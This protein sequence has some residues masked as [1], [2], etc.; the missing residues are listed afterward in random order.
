MIANNAR[1]D[2][3]LYGTPLSGQVH[4]A[5]WLLRMLELPYRP[6]DDAAE[7]RSSL[8]FRALNP[9]RQV[10]VLIDGAA[11]LADS[12]AILVYLAAGYAHG[13]A[14]LSRQALVAAQVQRWLSDAAGE[15]RY[16]PASARRV[17][18][19]KFPADLACALQIAGELLELMEQHV[20]TRGWLATEHPTLADLAC[21]S[22]VAHA[23]E[24]GVA[25]GPYPA[26]RGW[27]ARIEAL[28]HFKPMPSAAA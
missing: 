25:L 9:L 16:G 24:G 21:Y 1:A 19:W 4:R 27:L 17:V 3:T 22:Y 11:T 28:P 8:E 20:K 14:W 23:P 10:A 6:V 15:L 12:N 18:L 7:L 2:I 5:E 13:S 26:V